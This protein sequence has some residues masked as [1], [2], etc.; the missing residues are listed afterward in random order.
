MGENSYCGQVHAD[1]DDGAPE[2]IL[3]LLISMDVHVEVRILTCT[4][5]YV[6]DCMA[7]FGIQLCSS[8]AKGARSV[9][10]KDWEKQHT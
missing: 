4:S 2:V 10:G 9:P 7:R 1:G 3:P 6:H 5:E 8:I